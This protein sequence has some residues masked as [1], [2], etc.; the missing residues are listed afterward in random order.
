MA[1]T[2]ERKW[3]S[4]NERKRWLLAAPIG[5]KIAIYLDGKLIEIVEKVDPPSI[6][7]PGAT[8]APYG[9]KWS[10]GSVGFP[11]DP[12]GWHKDRRDDGVHITR[13][14]PTEVVDETALAETKTRRRIVRRLKDLSLRAWDRLTV[15]ELVAI[16]KTVDARLTT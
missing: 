2:T 11:I 12:S 3:L 8:R 16:E 15:E 6:L 7:I 14:E 1:D 5:T 4:R 10:N 13:Y 9:I